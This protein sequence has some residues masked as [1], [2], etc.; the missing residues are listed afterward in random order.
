MVISTE[1][2]N[3]AFRECISNL[4]NSNSSVS[5]RGLKTTEII[6]ANIV[7]N[8]PL[9]FTTIRTRK[10]YFYGELLWYLSGQNKLGMIEEYSD[11]WK[12]IAGPNGELN[13]NYGHYIFAENQISEIVNILI[14]DYS[15]R[16][17][18]INIFNKQSKFTNDT[19]CTL[20]LQY[21]IRPNGLN[22]GYSLIA[23]NT[24]RSQDILRGFVYDIPMFSIF[25]QIVCLLINKV[26]NNN[27]LNTNTPLQIGPMYHNV[28]SLHFYETDKEELLKIHNEHI[29]I[30]RPIPIFDMAA[31]NEVSDALKMEV[32]VRTLKEKASVLYDT[33]KFNS[34]FWNTGK[35]VLFKKFTKK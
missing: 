20:S 13:S 18:V 15:S 3:I 22:T 27:F 34:E 8:Q 23:I 24:M 32:E 21:L 11:F 25:Q 12:K 30:N 16:K 26:W 35:E 2:A 28:G 29:S 9:E 5:P 17:A 4:L 14:Q 19:T 33:Y 1:T 6:N 7:I 31:Y 10:S